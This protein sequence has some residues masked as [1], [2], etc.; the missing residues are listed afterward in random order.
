M[1]V[2]FNES[3]K[4]WVLGI[5]D[6]TVDSDGFLLDRNKQTLKSSCGKKLKCSDVIMIRKMRG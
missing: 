1:K 6:I 2:I 5:F 4:D 3:S